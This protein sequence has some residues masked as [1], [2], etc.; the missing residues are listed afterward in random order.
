MVEWKTKNHQGVLEKL[1]S[2]AGLTPGVGLRQEVLLSFIVLPTKNKH[3]SFP[4][5]Q[6]P[7]NEHF[8]EFSDPTT[9]CDNQ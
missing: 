5:E 8:L 7:L 4:V 1:S 6:V 9:T 2:I 3:C